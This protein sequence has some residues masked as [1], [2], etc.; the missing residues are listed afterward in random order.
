MVFLRAASR[1]KSNP[2]RRGGQGLAGYDLIT[3]WLRKS[4]TRS[5][6]T[7]KSQNQSS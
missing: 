5:D 3:S 2:L 4:V 7:G 6:A 1:R